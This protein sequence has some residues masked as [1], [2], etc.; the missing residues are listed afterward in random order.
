MSTTSS[1]LRI[2]VWEL[3]V[4][5]L[6]ATLSIPHELV[7]VKGY[8][9]DAMIVA[10]PQA[11]VLVGTTLKANWVTGPL[12]SLRLIHSTGAGTD[13][14]DFSA[15]PAGCQVCN[16]YGHE[17]TVAEY[18]FMTAAALNRNLLPQDREFRKGDWGDRQPRRELRGRNLLILGL[19][20]IG[21]EVA[22]WGAFLGMRVAGLT[23][24]PSAERAAKLGLAAYGG[25][26]DLAAHLPDAD[27][28]VIAIPQ[29]AQTTGLIGATALALMK[30]S[31]YLINVGRGPI[32]DEA[33]L[34][35]ALRDRTIAGAAVD[36]WYRYPSGG[37][38]V[39]PSTYP[40]HELDNI[41]MTPHNGGYSD[42]TMRFRWGFIAENLRRLSVGEPLENVV[43][44][45]AR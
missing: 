5:D 15:V 2:L 28:V 10:L 3:F 12:P 23:R 18:V 35:N 32:I 19:G 33:A 1:S 11:D 36:V 16:V 9:D 44:P 42:G 21:A 6:A 30:P 22:R 4:K 38:P 39:L 34:Y 24:T 29:S 7:V 40:L 43:W 37:E 13:G 25:L 17:Y 14:I 26:D 8:T 20:H 27:V 31:A 45:A 41:I